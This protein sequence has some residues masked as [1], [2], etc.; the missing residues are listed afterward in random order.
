MRSS[1]DLPVATKARDDVML[2]KVNIENRDRLLEWIVDMV[3]GL[4]AA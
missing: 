4:I 2:L 3:E 1:L